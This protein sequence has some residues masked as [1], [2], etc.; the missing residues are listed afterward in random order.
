MATCLVSSHL[1]EIV[2]RKET[3]RSI[4]PWF[5]H[6][7]CQKYVVS[8]AIMTLVCSLISG[9]PCPP[10]TPREGLWFLS[11][12]CDS[13]GDHYLPVWYNCPVCLSVSL[14]THPSTCY[15]SIYLYIYIDIYNHIWFLNSPTNQYVSF[16]FPKYPYWH[17]FL[18][19]PILPI[20]VKMLPSS[21]FPFIELVWYY[22]PLQ[23]SSVPTLMVSSCFPGFCSYIKS[24]LYSQM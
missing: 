20:S 7:L 5:H 9:L 13:W 2:P 6:V 23:S 1:W 11:V 10:V 8:A 14:L 22:L 12:V 24:K 4:S 19:L 18:L 15:L 21:I 3:F 17:S 16:D